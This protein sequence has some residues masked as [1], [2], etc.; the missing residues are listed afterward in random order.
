MGLEKKIKNAL[1]TAGLAVLTGCAYPYIKPTISEKSTSFET[2]AESKAEFTFPPLCLITKPNGE[3]VVAKA[4]EKEPGESYQNILVQ[5]MKDNNYVPGYITQSTAD[6]PKDAKF[7][8]TD[9]GVRSRREGGAKIEIIAYNCEIS[10]WD[11]KIQQS[12]ASTLCIPK[13]Y[14]SSATS[15]TF[16]SP[17]TSAQPAQSDK[18]SG[19]A[20]ILPFPGDEKPQSETPKQQQ[21]TQMPQ[22]QYQYPQGPTT[23]I[24]NNFYCTPQCPEVPSIPYPPQIPGKPKNPKSQKSSPSDSEPY[25]RKPHKRPRSG[26]DGHLW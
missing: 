2:K 12:K 8:P 21:Q 20:V 7:Y 26:K 23:T 4:Y 14:A 24:I 17:A 1:L 11:G 15:V 9:K 10:K 19:T 3:I 16:P 22:P 6:F 5:C 25:T 13:S 18:P